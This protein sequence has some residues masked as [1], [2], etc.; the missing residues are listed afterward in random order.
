MTQQEMEDILKL[1][2][3]IGRYLLLTGVSTE[4]T[5]INL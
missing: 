2:L 5:E 3:Y 1:E 4:A